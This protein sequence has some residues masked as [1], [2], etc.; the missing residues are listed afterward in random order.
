MNNS[1]ACKLSDTC[2]AW[3]LMPTP[4]KDDGQLL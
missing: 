4:R 3:N 1:N 2:K